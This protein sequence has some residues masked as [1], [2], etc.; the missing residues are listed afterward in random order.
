MWMGGCKAWV[1]V[2][3]CVCLCACVCVCVDELR[4]HSMSHETLA[5]KGKSG[6]GGGC[7]QKTRNPKLG[8]DL[9]T[10]PPY[11]F[12]PFSATFLPPAPPPTS[13][14]CSSNHLTSFLFHWTL[15][16]ADE[17]AEWTAIISPHILV[18]IQ[19][20]FLISPRLLM[21]K[22]NWPANSHQKMR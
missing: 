5:Q 20:S 13:P 11:S 2:L 18:H 21:K 14:L 7:Y 1:K 16:S 17:A 8:I 4:N 19:I 10:P 6:W 12:L 15:L 3:L 22:L 9:L